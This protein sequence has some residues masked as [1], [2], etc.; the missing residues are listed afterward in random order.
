LILAFH[1]CFQ[2][3]REG[4]KLLPEQIKAV[5]LNTLSFHGMMWVKL[6]QNPSLQMNNCSWCKMRFENVID[7]YYFVW[8]L[9]ISRPLSCCYICMLEACT[10]FTLEIM[11][12][13]FFSQLII[14]ILHNI[15]ST[16][17][18]TIFLFIDLSTVVFHR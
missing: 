18:I 15:M 10:P 8:K 12:Y 16:V 11:Q 2:Q 7:S 6:L 5:L 9:T 3:Y 13:Y 1:V 17:E 14:F 4:Q